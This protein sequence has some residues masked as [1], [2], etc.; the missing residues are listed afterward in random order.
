MKTDF[1]QNRSKVVKK[2]FSLL[3][4]DSLLRKKTAKECMVSFRFIS[5]AIFLVFIAA[6]ASAADYQCTFKNQ[7]QVNCNAV[8]AADSFCYLAGPGPVANNPAKPVSCINNAPGTTGSITCQLSNYNGSANSIR[9]SNSTYFVSGPTV[10]SAGANAGIGAGI[11]TGAASC[12]YNDCELN[13][14][15]CASGYAYQQCVPDTASPGCNKWQAT[16]C[17]GNAACYSTTAA[18]LATCVGIPSTEITTQGGVYMRTSAQTGAGNTGTGNA[19]AQGNTGNNSGNSNATPPQS[20]TINGKTYYLVRS[21]AA[22]NTGTKVCESLGK[23]C[24]GYTATSVSV[25][26]AF[27]PSAKVVSNSIHGSKAPYYCNGPPQVA[28]ACESTY[29]TCQECPQCNVNADCGTV[30]GEQFRAMFVECAGNENTKDLR[31]TLYQL[32]IIGNGKVN[33]TDEGTTP[34]AHYNATVSNGAVTQVSTGDAQNPKYTVVVSASASAAIK[35][36]SDPLKEALKQY[37]NGQVT[38]TTNDIIANL[39]LFVFKFFI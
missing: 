8:G 1:I 9:C 29:D 23:T 21:D 33:V 5:I 12:P 14:I 26:S 10:V 2:V 34:P 25:C 13:Q 18:Q 7:G 35:A 16:N 4:F 19:G 31:S 15:S 20:K 27:Y 38:V 3:T 22:N 39:Q 11:N 37:K 32:G 17:I 6:F 36:S 28:A 24:V 30:I